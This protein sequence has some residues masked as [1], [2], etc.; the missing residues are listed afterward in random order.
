MKG[1]EET[2]HYPHRQNLR[3]LDIFEQVLYTL[4]APFPTTASQ[5]GREV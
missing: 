2:S 4:T 5:T 3:H 1:F